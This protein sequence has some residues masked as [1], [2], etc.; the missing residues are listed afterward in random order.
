M[1]IQVVDGPTSAIAGEI[2]TGLVRLDPDHALVVSGPKA[3]IVDISSGSMSFGTQGTIDSGASSA[4]AKSTLVDPTTYRVVTINWAPSRFLRASIVTPN[5][6]TDAFTSSAQQ[7]RD[8]F[9]E[10]PSYPFMDFEGA[11]CLV[12]GKDVVAFWH[13]YDNFI[14]GSGTWKSFYM[15]ITVTGGTMTPGTAV[16]F[17]S[18]TVPVGYDVNYGIILDAIPTGPTSAILLM[19]NGSYRTV[20]VAGSSVTVG[21][22]TATAASSFV[23]KRGI[24]LTGGLAVG[25][26]NTDEIATFTSSFI[27]ITSSSPTSGYLA[28]LQ[29]R[30]AIACD[31]QIGQ[32]VIFNGN[33][34]DSL[35]NPFTY[36]MS[37][38][39][40]GY[41]QPM[42]AFNDKLL[43][44][45]GHGAGTF[46]T[47][48]DQIPT[49][50]PFGSD[51][52]N[53]LWI[54]KGVK[55][56]SGGYEWTSRGI[57]T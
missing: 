22:A 1:T 34:F 19:S 6:S 9:T 16:E 11:A 57:K 21:D 23:T 5:L 31:A 38:S 54:F 20:S 48:L 8:S 2:P 27:G 41:C 50:D 28:P 24:G 43:V 10:N 26:G 35:D 7:L 29:S 44:A 39:N 55:N 45:N 56:A 42:S 36:D 14:G 17:H 32:R 18:M 13:E 52:G 40:G 12:N 30:M 4:E 25:I 53:R 49:A 47:L 46:L 3:R 37:G 15:Y 33:S 51:S